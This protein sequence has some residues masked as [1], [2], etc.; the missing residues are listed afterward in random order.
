MG[1]TKK[2][3]FWPQDILRKL[4]FFPSSP[5]LPWLISLE[6][7]LFPRNRAQ[8]KYFPWFRVPIFTDWGFTVLAR[9][10]WKVLNLGPRKQLYNCQMGEPWLSRTHQEPEGFS[11]QE[12]QRESPAW[13]Y[14]QDMNVTYSCISTTGCR[15]RWSTH[16]M[17]FALTS[18]GCP[19]RTQTT[20]ISLETSH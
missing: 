20:S 12:A 16:Y 14:C 10:K 4:I 6:L 2:N 13:S 3:M 11:C 1:V 18:V 15:Q 5:L 7:S 17:S 8:Q 9:D 19:G